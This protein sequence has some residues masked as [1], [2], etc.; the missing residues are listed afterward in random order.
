MRESTSLVPR[1]A[2]G[3]AAGTSRAPAGEVCWKSRALGEEHGTSQAVSPRVL[4][5]PETKWALWNSSVLLC[6]PGFASPTVSLTDKF[7]RWAGSK[8]LQTAAKLRAIFQLSNRA[9]TSC[10]WPNGRGQGV[11]AVLHVTLQPLGVFWFKQLCT[12]SEQK[13]NA[14]TALVM[15]GF[16]DHFKINH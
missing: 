1:H 11:Q 10:T 7:I 2:G 5:T 4:S 6:P 9:V 8:V 14:I 13:A 12:A 16:L 15:P 3:A